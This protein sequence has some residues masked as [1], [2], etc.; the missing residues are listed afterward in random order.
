MIVPLR[1]GEYLTFGIPMVA[2]CEVTLPATS[3]RRLIHLFP[4]AT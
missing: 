1:S 3:S 2:N 4:P